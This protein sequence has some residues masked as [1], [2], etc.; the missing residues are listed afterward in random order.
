MSSLMQKSRGTKRVTMRDIANRTGFTINT[1]SHALKNMPD[2]SE[3]TRLKIHE[4]AKDLGYV[5][6][7][8]ASA[9][10]SG[11][12][13]TIAVIIGDLG[14]PKFAVMVNDIEAAAREY[15]Y[16]VIILC[17]HESLDLEEKAIKTALERQVDGIIINP[18]QLNDH[19]ISQL[20]SAGIPFVLIE[21]YFEQHDVDCVVC[22][23]EEGGY[24]AGK[25]LLDM[26]H[27]RLIHFS[28][29]PYVSTSA[30]R[31]AGF[32]R[33]AQHLPKKDV[34]VLPHSDAKENIKALRKLYAQGFTGCF[35]YLDLGVWDVI[36]TLQAGDPDFLGKIAFVGYDNIQGKFS[37][38]SPICSIDPSSSAL[39]HA[40][41]DLLH[42][43]IM[44]EETPPQKIVFPVR[45]VCRKSCLPQRSL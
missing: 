31:R 19:C 13:H 5:R 33:A 9:L 41:V 18:T 1:V 29:P 14:N 17:T 35:C 28:G 15:Q 23:E 42:R 37:F 22:D 20:R 43:R 16:S 7:T 30:A 27:R 25:H 44:G 24:L 3:G 8:M 34:I 6:N 32:L 4:A 39:C 45:L 21:R 26:G 38:P 10:R 2:I 40:T 36:A 12:S 11:R